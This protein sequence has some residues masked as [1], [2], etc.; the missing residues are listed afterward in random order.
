M[1][2]RT[3]VAVAGGQYRLASPIFMPMRAFIGSRS[4][5]SAF[6]HIDDAG[7]ASMVD[8]S[9][10]E[11]T[12]R[13]AIARGRVLMNKET[14]D[15]VRQDKIEKGNVLN[16]AQIAG[17]QG[18]KN[19]SQIIPLCHPIAITKVSVDLK[20]TKY[21]A[22]SGYAVEIESQ[23]RCKG[24]TGVEMEAL[25]AV[26]AAALTVFDMCK[27]VSKHMRIGDIRVV[28]KTGGKSGHWSSGES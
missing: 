18:A 22:S 12:L 10:K 1:S 7:N 9:D 4:A 8:V 27:A 20:L 21:V 16:V 26:S 2:S 23:V 17:I 15:L 11:P 28:E 19:C 5:K 25:S 14:F 3:L 24:E 13:T 6:T